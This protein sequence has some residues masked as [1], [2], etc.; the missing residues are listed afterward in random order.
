MVL[1]PKVTVW[2]P[3]SVREIVGSYF[4][5]DQ[6]RNTRIVNIERYM[7]ILQNFLAP[8]LH[9][10]SGFTEEHSSNK[11]GQ[12]VTPPMNRERPYMKC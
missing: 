4:N 5:E 3:V 10:I 9:N 12:P 8:V 6:R 1:L 7:K 2:V 11:S